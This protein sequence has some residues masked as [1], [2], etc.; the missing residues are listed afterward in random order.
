MIKFGSRA[1]LYVPERPDLKILVKV[2]DKVKA[3]T[4]PLAKYEI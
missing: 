1:E 3:G 2:G 4:T